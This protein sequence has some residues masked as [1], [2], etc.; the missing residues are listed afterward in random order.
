V[1]IVLEHGYDFAPAPVATAAMILA[2]E[3]V[4]RSALSSRATVEATDVGFFRL[5]VA[6]PGRPTGVP[7]VDA[8]VAEF[9]RRRPRT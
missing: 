8:A 2:R 1:S 3:Y 6:G 9:G 4:F 5:S 7:E